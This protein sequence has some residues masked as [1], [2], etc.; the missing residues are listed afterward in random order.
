MPFDF[1]NIQYPNKLG[2]TQEEILNTLADLALRSDWRDQPRYKETCRRWYA[3]ERD[4]NKGTL[5]ILK[6][7]ERS[8]NKPDV[9]AKISINK[10]THRPHNP[11][12]VVEYF[13]WG[14]DPALVERVLRE[15]V[16]QVM[17]ESLRDHIRP[18]YPE[19]KCYNRIEVEGQPPQ[20][21]IPI[22]W[23]DWYFINGYTTSPAHHVLQY[24]I[25]TEFPGTDPKK[26]EG[27]DKVLADG[28]I[29]LTV[30]HV[31]KQQV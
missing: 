19:P 28:S 25:D 20:R 2:N 21:I 10:P 15:I 11:K 6:Y 12:Y 27:V 31:E 18:V 22:E 29:E 14:E 7:G 3:I 4:Y 23:I 5:V 1:G 26:K 17:P 30:Y 9:Y 16:V 8:Y 13:Q 24:V